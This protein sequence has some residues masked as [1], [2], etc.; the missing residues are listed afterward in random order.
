MMTTSFTINH[1]PTKPQ[2]PSHI[3]RDTTESIQDTLANPHTT[4]TITESNVL[5]IPTHDVTENTNNLFHQKDASTLS[6]INTVD[7][8]PLQTRHRQNYGPPP[9]PSEKS[10]HSSPTHS[11]QQGSSN[12]F[13]NREHT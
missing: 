12:S 6:T 7:T 5:Q 3:T 2:P 8:Q 13:R 4:S 11:P 10:T 9:P 1:Q